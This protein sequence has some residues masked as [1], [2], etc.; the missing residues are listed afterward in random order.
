MNVMRLSIK[1]YDLSDNLRSLRLF[2]IEDAIPVGF[3]MHK[4]YHASNLP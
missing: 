4:Q 3:N 1:A 2:I